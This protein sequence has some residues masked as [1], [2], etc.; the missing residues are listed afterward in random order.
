MRLRRAQE[1][2]LTAEKAKAADAEAKY[3]QLRSAAPAEA[4]TGGADGSGNG[5]AAAAQRSAG[6]AGSAGAAGNDDNDDD[7]DPSKAMWDDPA[8]SQDQAPAAAAPSAV[9]GGAATMPGDAV[10]HPG[11]MQQGQAGA[12][13]GLLGPLVGGGG[14]A[15]MMPGSL[16]APGGAGAPMMGGWGMGGGFGAPPAMQPPMLGADGADIG[17]LGSV[18]AALQQGGVMGGLASSAAAPPT[19]DGAGGDAAAGAGGD[20]SFLY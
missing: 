14:G 4:L 20:D 16:L 15:G 10:Q 13:F 5:A 6:G 17:G 7:Y 8:P 9:E 3:E 1:A 12:L 11:L 19:G 18:L 2:L